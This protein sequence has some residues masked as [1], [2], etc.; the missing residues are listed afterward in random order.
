MIKAKFILDGDTVTGFTVSGH[1][2]FSEAGSDIV[3]AAVSSAAYMAANTVT[4]VLGLHPEISESEG[5]LSLRLSG[6]ETEKA[7]DILT[8]FLLHMEGLREQYPE[9]IKIERGA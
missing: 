2:G 9:F 6:N 1:S 8:G 5:L 3:C 7:A 4:D